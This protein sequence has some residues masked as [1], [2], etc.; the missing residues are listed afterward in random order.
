MLKGKFIFVVV[1]AVAAAAPSELSYEEDIVEILRQNI[2]HNDDHS[3]QHSFESENGISVSESGQPEDDDSYSVSGQF[4]YTAPDGVT[5]TVVYSAGEQGFQA[6]GDH[7][8]TPVPTQYPTPE[9]ADDEEEEGEQEEEEEEGEEESA[10]AGEPVY[11]RV[12]VGYRP[13]YN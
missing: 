10:A 4:S 11:E 1:L 3:Y 6:Q 5:Y 9:V 7:L 2:D 13:R 8:P 12:I